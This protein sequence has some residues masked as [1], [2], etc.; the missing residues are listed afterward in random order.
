MIIAVIVNILTM[1]RDTL[2]PTRV[3]THLTEV[4]ADPYW[5]A[6]LVWLE[7]KPDNAR[8]SYYRAI[9]ALARF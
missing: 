2:T 8:R 1:E 9:Q 6:W 5:Q 7:G 4:T 3:D